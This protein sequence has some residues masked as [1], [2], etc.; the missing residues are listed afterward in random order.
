[1]TTMRLM[2]SSPAVENKTPLAIISLC[3]YTESE[4]DDVGTQSDSSEIAC[5]GKGRFHSEVEAT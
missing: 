3:M 4:D 2:T 5:I 1:M